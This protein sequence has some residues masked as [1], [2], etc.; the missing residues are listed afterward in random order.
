MSTWYLYKDNKTI[1]L[2][3]MRIIKFMIT[4]RHTNSLYS[5]LRTGSIGLGSE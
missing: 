2:K 4:N 3:K 5:S 1:T